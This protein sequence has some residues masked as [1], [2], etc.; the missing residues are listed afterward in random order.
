MDNLPAIS[1]R[2]QVIFRWDYEY[3]YFVLDQHVEMDFYSTSSLKQQST[4]RRVASLRHLIL[5][6]SKPVSALSLNTVW[7]VQKKQITI[8]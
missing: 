6:P 5:F 4:G 7:F 1:W 3:V 8:N 2:E